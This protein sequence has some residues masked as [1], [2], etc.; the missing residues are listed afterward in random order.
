MDHFIHILKKDS[1]AC[2]TAINYPIAPITI[3]AHLEKYKFWPEYISS[4]KP[5][6]IDAI[7]SNCLVKYDDKREINVDLPSS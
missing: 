5:L 6:I 7:N 3:L 4:D 2:S 1:H